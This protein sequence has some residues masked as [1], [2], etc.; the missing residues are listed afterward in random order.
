MRTIALSIPL[1]LSILFYSPYLLY[2]QLSKNAVSKMDTKSQEL[3]NSYFKTFAEFAEEPKAQQPLKEDIY[4]L[5]SSKRKKIFYNIFNEEKRDKR[6]FISPRR[7]LKTIEKNFPMGMGVLFP[8]DG[9]TVLERRKGITSS[10]LVYKV[11]V[12]YSGM[13][14]D[15]KGATSI[16]N[17][18]DDQYFYVE[19]YWWMENSKPKIKRIGNAKDY[20]RRFGKI[21]FCQGLFVEP[22]I[23]YGSAAFGGYFSNNSPGYLFDY[24]NANFGANALLMIKPFFGLGAGLQRFNYSVKTYFEGNFYDRDLEYR[25]GS[26]ELMR[27]VP[28]PIING[29]EVDYFID[30]LGEEHRISGTTSTIFARLQWGGKNSGMSV[31]VGMG[32]TSKLRNDVYLD[33]T[34]RSFGISTLTGDTLFTNPTM[35]FGTYT[36]KGDLAKSYRIP[37]N[38]KYLL[39][40]WNLVNLQF[41]RY[42][43]FRLSATGTI[44]NF[45]HRESLH[46]FDVYAHHINNDNVYDVDFEHNRRTMMTLSFEFAI[47]VKLTDLILK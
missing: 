39:M 2:S 36:Y 35:G 24:T 34:A 46:R 20:K 6:G 30:G 41:S 38:Q 31:D 29:Y 37:Q 14:T 32:V 3:L 18:S 47:G 26:F 15:G 16:F 40:R 23:S 12:E 22:F 10:T 5:Y 13:Q 27:M 43:Y 28:I 4:S 8:A 21:L 17:Y 7:K 44:M 9:L 25:D 33:G 45:Y 42:Y 19:N 11:P 1:I